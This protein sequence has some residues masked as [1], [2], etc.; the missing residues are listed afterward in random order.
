MIN[1][2]KLSY[3]SSCVKPYFI[4]TD[5]KIFDDRDNEIELYHSTN[6]YLYVPLLTESGLRLYPVDEIVLRNMIGHDIGFSGV[7]H[8]DGN[9]LNNDIS[10]LR[11]IIENESWRYIDRDDVQKDEYQISNFGGFINKRNVSYPSSTINSRGYICVKMMSNDGTVISDV[12]HRLVA[13]YFVH[14]PDEKIYDEVNHI[15]GD[16]TNNYWKNLEWVSHKMNM[17]HAFKMGMI[18]RPKGDEVYLTKISPSIVHEICRLFSKYYGRAESV[19]NDIRQREPDVTLK[20]IQ[21]IKHKECWSHISDK[22]WTRSDLDYLNEIKVRMICECL[23]QHSGDTMN[24]LKS[25]EKIIPDITKRYVEIIKYKEDYAE[26]SDEYFQKGYFDKRL[27]DTDIALIRE[28][29]FKSGMN[30][31][32]TYNQLSNKIKNLTRRKVQKIRYKMIDEFKNGGISPHS[33]TVYI[34]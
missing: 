14:N 16:K 28:A 18:Y 2:Y 22:Y 15:D 12:L 29:L 27:T 11:W 24:T 26:I 19:Y 23:I 33:S 6:G 30:V 3:P 13:T 25:L 1:K 32:Q 31:D 9:L 8:I 7:K 20:M 10:N 5:G 34:W 4:T 21:H 17:Q